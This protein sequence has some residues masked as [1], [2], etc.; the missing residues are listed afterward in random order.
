MATDK[1]MIDYLR[2]VS[3][4]NPIRTVIDDLVRSGLGAMIIFE[5]PEMYSENLFEGGFKINCRF[6]S[7][8][9]FELCKLDGAIMV[10]EDLT[11]ILYANILITPDNTIS[12]QETGTRHKA[13]ERCAKQA[14]TFVVA[15]SERRKKTTLYLYNSRY[16]LKSSDELIRDV[17]ANLQ[18]LE[19][20]RSAFDKLLE[21]LDILEIS[22]MVSAVDVCKVIQKT[23]IM[24]RISDDIKRQIIEIGNEGKIINMRFKELIRDYE[25]IENEIIRDYTAYPLKKTRTLLQNLSFEDILNLESISELILEKS[26]EETVEPNGYRFL[27]HLELTDKEISELV[28]EFKSLNSILNLEEKDLEIVFKEKHEIIKKEI[29]HLREQILSGKNV[30]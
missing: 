12:T 5:T 9:L 19:D 1:K 10:S 27:S 8:R 24:D 14:D 7:Q 16:Y 6:T 17:T 23:E 2:K 29:D 20:Q 28:Q 4:G 13:A 21:K 15:T 11:R 30:S 3:P 22:E 18:V 25:K 26:L